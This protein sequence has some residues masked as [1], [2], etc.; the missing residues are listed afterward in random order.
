VRPETG[1]MGGELNEVHLVTASGVEAWPRLPKSE[2]AKRL[3]HR[4]AEVL[5]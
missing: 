3:A 5:A 4:I 2:V 1:I